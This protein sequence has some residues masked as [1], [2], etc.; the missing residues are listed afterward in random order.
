[1]Q[2]ATDRGRSALGGCPAASYVGGGP[3]RTLPD[4]I[5]VSRRACSARQLSPIWSRIFRLDPLQADSPIVAGLGHD[6]RRVVDDEPTNSA[7][8]FSRY[9]V[10]MLNDEEFVRREGLSLVTPDFIRYDRRRLTS[11]PPADRHEW[12]VALVSFGEV[13][14]SWPEYSVAEVVSVRCERL[15]LF[16][17]RARFADGSEIRFLIVTRTDETHERWELSIFYDPEDVELAAA[18]LDRLHDEIT[19]G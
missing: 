17:L 11:Q 8:E 18:E 15:A 6:Y 7:A 1:M 9:G 16:N 4:P 10:G 5:G 13:S 12:L 3:A 19:R 2:R 14:G